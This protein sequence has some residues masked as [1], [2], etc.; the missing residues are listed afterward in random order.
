[1]NSVMA[2]KQGYSWLTMPALAQ[3]PNSSPIYRAALEGQMSVGPAGPIKIFGGVG[4]LS[5]GNAPV[6]PTS[7]DPLRLAGM[8]MKVDIDVKEVGPS[9]IDT[10]G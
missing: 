8:V 7:P 2:T 3:P 1:M 5:V 10:Y 4:M 6:S 9:G